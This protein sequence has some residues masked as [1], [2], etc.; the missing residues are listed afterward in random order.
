MGSFENRMSGCRRAPRWPRRSVIVLLAILVPFGIVTARLFVW[1]DLPELPSRADAIIELG[2]PGNRDGAALALA[3]EHRA[4]VV[5]Q[6]TVVVE[7]GTNTCLPPIPDVTTMCF[8]PNPGTTRGEARYIGAVAAELQWKSVILV[9]SQD[10]AWRARLRVMR[11]F[12][13][14]VY[15]QTS[16]LPAWS[17]LRQIPYQWG[18]TIKALLLQTA[19]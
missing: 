7:A 16:P 9:T 5:I 14:E 13:G 2:G 4:P 1:P 6:S 11:C 10:H 19:C 18:A 8:H 15:V 12:P 3:R 17:W